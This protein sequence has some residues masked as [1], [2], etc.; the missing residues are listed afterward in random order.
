MIS[1]Q[2]FLEQVIDNFK[3]KGHDFNNIEERYTITIANTM[4][5]KCH[6]V[7]ILNIKCMQLNEN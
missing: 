6:M 7:S 2:N 1:W 3:N 5:I 4:D